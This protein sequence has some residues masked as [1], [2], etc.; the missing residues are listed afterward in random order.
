MDKTQLEHI[1]DL[2]N[3]AVTCLGRLNNNYVLELAPVFVKSLD[4]L[5]TPAGSRYQQILLLFSVQ[6]RISFAEEKVIG[7]L[8]HDSSVT[9]LQTSDMVRIRLICHELLINLMDAIESLKK[10]RT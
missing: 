2:I 4:T 5:Q 6:R 3:E 10:V 1:I 9:F 7:G 8:I